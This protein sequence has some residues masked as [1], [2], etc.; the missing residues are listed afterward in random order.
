MNL[1][2]RRLSAASS[3][4]AAFEALFTSEYARVV[5]IANRVLADQHEA[6]DVAQEVFIDFHRLHSA[7]AGYGP[8]WLHRAAAHAS[9]NRLR[10]SRRRQKREVAH[11][12]QEGDRTLDPQHQ[13]ELNEDRRRVRAALGRLAPKPAAVLVLRASGLSYA[14]VAQALG[15]G[16]GQVGTLLRR[17]EAALRKE[18][19]RGTSL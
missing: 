18:V 6:E 14:E 8:A 17:A 9:L 7:T 4:D 10:G 3:E 2:A 13:A 11:V 1:G 16:I 5:G 15:V 19:T 12:V